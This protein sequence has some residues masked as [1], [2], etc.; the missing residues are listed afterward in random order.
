MDVNRPLT[1]AEFT[2]LRQQMESHEYMQRYLASVRKAAETAILQAAMAEPGSISQEQ[3]Y[4][5]HGKY[6]MISELNR[7]LTGNT[8]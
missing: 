5:L 3:L 4:V 6:A 8:L 7:L 2:K 1:K